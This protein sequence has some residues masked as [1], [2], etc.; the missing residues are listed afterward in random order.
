MPAPVLSSQSCTARPAVGGALP[1]T[2]GAGSTCQHRNSSLG[3]TPLE[4][5]CSPACTHRSRRMSAVVARCLR[6]A[7]ARPPG[8][9]HRPGNFVPSLAARESSHRLFGLPAGSASSCCPGLLPP[10]LRRWAAPNWSVN[11]TAHSWAVAA[12]LRRCYLRRP[13]PP[14]QPWSARYLKR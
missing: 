5:A 12:C 3:R 8:A 2:L 10:C 9:L 11:A 14:A 7:P 13:A 6:S 4:A 1:Q